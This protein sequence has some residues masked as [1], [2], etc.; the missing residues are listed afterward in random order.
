MKGRPRSS[1][2]PRTQTP[3]EAHPPRK[4]TSC[5]ILLD[6]PCTHPSCDGHGNAR[7]GDMC[8]YCATHA[9]L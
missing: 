6:V 7:Q 4:C 5:G 9:R 3:P 2:P 1:R 8:V